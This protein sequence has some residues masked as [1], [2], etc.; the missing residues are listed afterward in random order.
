MARNASYMMRA[1]S[2]SSEANGASEPS[3][4]P[5]LIGDFEAGDSA[6][7]ASVN[8]AVPIL[9][10]STVS[11]ARCSSASRVPR[12][13]EPGVGIFDAAR[14]KLARQRSDRR[15]AFV[16]KESADRRF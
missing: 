3:W 16:P 5:I 11:N 12:E 1:A 10:C 2:T 15:I 13:P 8:E 14:E 7:R 4:R 9:Q 6:G